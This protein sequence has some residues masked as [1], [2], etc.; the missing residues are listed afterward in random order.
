MPFCGRNNW[1]KAERPKTVWQVASQKSFVPAS[2]RVAKACIDIIIIIIGLL[3]LMTRLMSQERFKMAPFF[4]KQP[5]R[6]SKIQSH[7]EGWEKMM[8]IF[9][10]NEQESEYLGIFFVLGWIISSII[11]G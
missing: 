3:P 6:D 4:P 9:V 10:G 5:S 1:L 7:Q 8:E 2:C 11:C